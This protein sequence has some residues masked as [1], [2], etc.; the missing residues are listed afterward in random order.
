[1]RPYWWLLAPIFAGG[2]A[3]GFSGNWKLGVTLLTATGLASLFWY[4]QSRR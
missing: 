4:N 1:M 3:W 2:V